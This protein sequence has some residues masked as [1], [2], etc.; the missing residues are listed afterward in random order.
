M[1]D[2]ATPE[3]HPRPPM[4]FSLDNLGRLVVTPSIEQWLADEDDE[5]R[6]VS[7]K[8][9][10]ESLD[11]HP[12]AQREQLAEILKRLALSKTRELWFVAYDE[13]LQT[14]HW[15]YVRGRTI[16]AAAGQCSRCQ[17]YDALQVHHL[18]YKHLGDEKPEDLQALC[19]DCHLLAHSN[20]PQSLRTAE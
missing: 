13:Y 16:C 20:R 11:A 19:K 10:L 14:P 4:H 6:I 17:N 9:A 15:K 3:R 8:Q 5:F 2:T 7:I 12:D 1:V 18:S